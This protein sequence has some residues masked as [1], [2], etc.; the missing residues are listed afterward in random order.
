MVFDCDR[1]SACSCDA[2]GLHTTSGKLEAIREAPT[3][4]TQL[5]SFLGL[6]NYYGNFIANLATLLHPLNNLL[7][8]GVPWKWSGECAKHSDMLLG[9]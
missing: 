6:L 7:R 8:Q 2:K 9:P 3:P 4:V 5:R 1:S